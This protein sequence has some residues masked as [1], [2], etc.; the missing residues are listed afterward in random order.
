MITDAS[1][2]MAFQVIRD[3]DEKF[4]WVGRP[5][6]RAPFLASGLPFLVIGCIWGAMDYFGFI[7]HMGGKSGIP[8]GF[9]VPF[10]MIHLFPFWGSVLNML[11]LALV[12]GNT[13]YAVT[14]K[15]LMLRSGFWGTDFRSIDFDQIANLEVSVNPIENASNVGSIRFYSRMPSANGNRLTL[16]SFVGIRDPYEVFKLVKKTLDE[17][18]RAAA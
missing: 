17:Q 13:Y 5:A 8:L 1:L 18:P 9:A 2:P 16:V 14:P 7:R 3:K 12:V 4:L 6:A 10:F 15:R 11:R